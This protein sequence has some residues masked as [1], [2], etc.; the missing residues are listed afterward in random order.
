MG[1]HHREVQGHHLLAKQRP[2]PHYAEVRVSVEQRT[3]PTVYISP[4]AFSWLRQAYGDNAKEGPGLDE[5]KQEA[6]DGATFA[7][8]EAGVGGEVTVTEIRFQTRRYCRGR[9]AFRCGL[10]SVGG[11]RISTERPTVDRRRRRS[12]PGTMTRASRSCG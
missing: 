4:N 1:W 6:L 8:T 11:T 12:L 9:R 2:G 5:F 10:R 3:Q 7:L